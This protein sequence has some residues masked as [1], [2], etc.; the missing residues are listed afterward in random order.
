MPELPE[1]ET[2]R[3]V[4]IKDLV[5][6]KITDVI[7]KYDGIIDMDNDLFKSSVIG[8]TIKN[9]DRYGKYLI[10]NLNEGNIISHL[11]MEGKYF[12]LPNDGIDNKHIHVIYKFDNGYSLFYQDVRKFGKMIYKENNELFSTNPL[13]NIGIDPILTKKIDYRL[14]YDKIVSRNVAIK[15]TLL[16]QSIITGLGNIYVDEVL[17]EA[18]INPHRPSNSMSFEDVKHI[19]DASVE[20]LSKAIEYKGTTIRSYTSSLGVEGQY[21]QFLKVHTKKICSICKS[22]LNCDKING[23]TTYYCENCER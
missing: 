13:K 8:K 3:R 9:I 6:L 4:L 1:V 11:R 12:Y 19:C 10:F 5:N 14:I 16:D 7:I 2:V 20:I 15:T 18:K 22:T 21:Q 23:R 17:F